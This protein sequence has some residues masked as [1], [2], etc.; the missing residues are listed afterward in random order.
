MKLEI[1]YNPGNVACDYLNINDDHR[2]IFRVFI[3]L[4]YYGHILGLLALYYSKYF[5]F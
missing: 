5:S 1:F 2:F 3:N 4:T